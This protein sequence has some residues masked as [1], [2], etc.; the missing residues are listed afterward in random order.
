MSKVTTLTEQ[1]KKFIS[2]HPDSEAAPLLKEVLRSLNR[3]SVGSA[4]RE[5]AARGDASA[6]LKTVMVALSETH[7]CA[8]CQGRVNATIVED[9]D[10]AD[11]YG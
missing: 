11:Y 5:A 9:V 2:E 6:F 8:S 7:L 3:N 10:G 1:V 4:I